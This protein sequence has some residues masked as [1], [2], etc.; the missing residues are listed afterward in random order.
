MDED[1]ADFICTNSHETAADEIPQAIL[2]I[3]NERARLVHNFNE[4]VR[5]EV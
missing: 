2:D 3:I 4:N 5:W 1:I